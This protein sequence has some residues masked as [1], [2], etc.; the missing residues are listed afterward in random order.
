M[1]LEDKQKCD[2]CKN[3]MFIDYNVVDNLWDEVIGGDGVF[4]IDCF[5]LKCSE[6]KVVVNRN[7]C[8]HLGIYQRPLMS[9]WAEI[10]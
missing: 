5:I 1:E 10:I 9:E 6:K 3:Y 4:C 2:R 7:S 8:T